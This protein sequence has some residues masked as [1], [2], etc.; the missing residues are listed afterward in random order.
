MVKGEPQ[1][2]SRAGP[3]YLDAYSFR[4]VPR[5][6]IVGHPSHLYFI[7]EVHEREWL[8]RE[9]AGLL[10]D[11]CAR[12]RLSFLGVEYFNVEQQ[13]LVDS[14]LMGKISF[15]DLAREYEKGPEGFDLYKYRPMLETAR[16]CG[17]RII[18]VM[19]PRN[20][21]NMVAR[22]GRIP[23]GYEGIPD[24]SILV[25][26]YEVLVSSLFP[27]QGPMA[28]IP[29]RGLLLAQS[30]KDSVAALRVAEASR[31]GPGAVVMGWVHV[32]VKGAVATRTSR[33]LGLDR[34][35][36]LVLGAGEGEEKIE[37]TRRNRDLLETDYL[38]TK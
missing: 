23:E 16:E 6:E 11:L 35:D 4:I 32:E 24:P 2:S 26:E 34:R 33:L 27:K 28:R 29:L 15:E 36:Y 9:V 12:G 18:G 30:F 38:L 7:G 8:I 31:M 37:F 5:A 21:A 3:V 17:A 25:R 13:E 10:T 19:P 1:V 14:W 20:I 22:T